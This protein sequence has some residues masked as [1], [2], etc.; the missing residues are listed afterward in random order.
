MGAGEGGIWPSD[1]RP[2]TGKGDLSS[3]DSLSTY[4][5]CAVRPGAFPM[6]TDANPVLL[7]LRPQEALGPDGSGPPAC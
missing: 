5:V 3:Q 1:P 7:S 6:G 2:P 4:L